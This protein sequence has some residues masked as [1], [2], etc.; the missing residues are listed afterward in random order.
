MFCEALWK[1]NGQGCRISVKDLYLVDEHLEENL[2]LEEFQ[3]KTGP[4]AHVYFPARIAMDYNSEEDDN[5]RP[6]FKPQSVV[7]MKAT[8]DHWARHR[9]SKNDSVYFYDIR[10]KKAYYEF[11]R[12]PAATADFVKTLNSMIVWNWPEDKTV[13]MDYIMSH[14][15]H[16]L[17]KR[18]FST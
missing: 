3:M 8:E 10:R 2:K 14:I 6:Y 9:S 4:P 12:P 1:P 5:E 13:T 18:Q 16:A 17:V 15:R 7:F 11:D